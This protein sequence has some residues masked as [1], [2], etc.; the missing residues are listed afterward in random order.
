MIAGIVTLLLNTGCATYSLVEF[1]AKP[2]YESGETLYEGGRVPGQPAYYALVPF[3]L[4]FDIVTSP[5]QLGMLCAWP[6]VKVKKPEAATE[7]SP[8]NAAD[9]GTV[10]DVD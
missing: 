2:H 8:P 4:A 5:I 9:C 10:G 1:K 7:M 6:A 3:T